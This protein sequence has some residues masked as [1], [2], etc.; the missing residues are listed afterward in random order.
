MHISFGINLIL[1]SSHSELVSHLLPS[2]SK[3]RLP[4]EQVSKQLLPFFMMHIL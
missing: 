3:I 2:V 4:F 1:P